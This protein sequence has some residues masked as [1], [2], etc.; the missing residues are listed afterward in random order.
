MDGRFDQHSVCVCN[1]V[2]Y[3]VR[4]GMEPEAALAVCRR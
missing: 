4:F 1:E 3:N 2:G